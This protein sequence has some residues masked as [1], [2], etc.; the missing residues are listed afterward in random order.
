MRAVAPPARFQALLEAALGSPPA[1]GAPL[2]DALQ[3]AVIG[4]VARHAPEVDLAPVR[5]R[6]DMKPAQD[7]EPQSSS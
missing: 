6:L 2:L 7:R 1:N 5:A 3:E 4:L